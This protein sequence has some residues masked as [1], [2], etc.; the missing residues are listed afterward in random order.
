MTSLEVLLPVEIK[1]LFEMLS[2]VPKRFQLQGGHVRADPGFLT[3]WNTQSELF[4]CTVMLNVMLHLYFSQTERWSLRHLYLRNVQWSD[5]QDVSFISQFMWQEKKHFHLQYLGMR[6]SS[7]ASFPCPVT[8][9]LVY[10]TFTFG[11][12][13][14]G[15]SE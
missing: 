4:T 1:M 9:E 8:G 11:T 13:G 3:N 10:S 2:K 5:I 7:T 14:H 6:T 12:P 15:Y